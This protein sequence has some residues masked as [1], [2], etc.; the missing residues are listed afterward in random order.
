MSNLVRLWL[1]LAICSTIIMVVGG[2][3]LV[4]NSA[5]GWAFFGVGVTG[6]G[7]FVITVL[8]DSINASRRGT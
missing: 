6:F 3:L 8:L 4:V 5:G 7:L 2:L 1:T